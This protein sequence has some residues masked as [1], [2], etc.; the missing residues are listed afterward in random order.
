MKRYRVRLLVA[1]VVGAG[2]VG[3]VTLSPSPAGATTATGTVPCQSN[4][5]QQCQVFTVSPA[6]T[7]DIASIKIYE[8]NGALRK[9]LQPYGP[10]K[11]EV[12]VRRGDVDG[13]GDVELVTAV[14]KGGSAHIRIWSL[15]GAYEAQFFA[16][17]KKFRGGVNV[18]LG[19]FNGDGDAEIAVAPR[20]SGGP[21]VRVF[22]YDSATGQYSLVSQFFADTQ[23]LRSGL[24]LEAGDLDA[25]GD[26]E[27][28]TSPLVGPGTVHGFAWDGASFTELFAVQPFGD[29]YQGGYKVRVGD[30]TGG[31]EAEVIVSPR[32]D[33]NPE[34]KVYGWQ[35]EALALL[36]SFLAYGDDTQS[37]ETV[38][39]GLALRLGNIAG[40]EQLEIIT[41]PWQEPSGTIRVWQ[42]A[43]TGAFQVIASY[44]T[45][46]AYGHGLN[47]L[48]RDVA[49]D[50][51]GDGH[52]EIVVAPRGR[53]VSVLYVL[54]YN[55][56]AT[57]QLEL[58]KKWSPFHRSFS[59]EVKLDDTNE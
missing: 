46:N 17:D 41:A 39:T 25:D 5:T 47:V 31:S 33:A 54:R 38:T 26:D 52:E 2:L 18:A 9:V 42:P 8:G 30:V 59:G 20:K 35:S 44:Q 11:G 43:A 56:A 49:P 27:L 3:A 14:S 6:G 13:D 10:F 37:T 4:T 12:L 58:I 50:R 48:T 53:A 16:F 57:G 51:E 7:D 32:V 21:Q 34:I 36:T 55:P 40:S 19:D 22:D 28:V 45:T 1:L 15:T 23:T 29:T 24:M